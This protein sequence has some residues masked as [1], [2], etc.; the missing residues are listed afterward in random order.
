LLRTGD[1]LLLNIFSAHDMVSDVLRGSVDL[2]PMS[3]HLQT[4][5][6]VIQT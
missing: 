3:T 6:P 5:Q 1:R 4:G 2:L